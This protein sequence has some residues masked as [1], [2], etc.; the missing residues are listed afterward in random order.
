MFSSTTAAAAGF[1]CLAALSAQV[2]AFPGSFQGDVTKAVPGG[3]FGSM[4]IDKYEATSSDAC[5]IT[6]DIP[7]EGFAIG[8]KYTF[9]ISTN[10]GYKTGLGMV[11]K[12]G[13][14]QETVSMAKSKAFAWTGAG[15][16]ISA[17]AIC[18]AMG[19]YDKMH[20][21]ESVTAKK[22]AK[23][24]FAPLATPS[25]PRPPANPCLA[26]PRPPAAARGGAG[27]SPA[28]RR[29]GWMP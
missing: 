13:A 24:E 2:R 27:A 28:A 22:A 20:A 5:K 21:A 6:H 23:R 12:V 1:A 18:G 29:N 15:D 26:P 17:F 3:A 19:S 8:D 4:G 11:Y 10:A 25:Q 14:Q 7:A 16:V 9:T